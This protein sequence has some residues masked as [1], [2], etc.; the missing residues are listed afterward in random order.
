MLAL[1]HHVIVQACS[2]T[3]TLNYAV[4]GD[5][6][7]IDG[8]LSNSYINL[9]TSLGVKISLP[10]S[11]ISSNFIE[12][13]KRFI[14]IKENN[15]FTTLGPGLI[16]ASIR[17]RFLIPLLIS[18]SFKRKLIN[19]PESVNILKSFKLDFNFGLF[20][21]FG[22]NGLI[23]KDHKAHSN[24]GVLWLK[25]IYNS[26]VPLTALQ[27]SLYNALVS[28]LMKKHQSAVQKATSSLYMY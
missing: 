16:L 4:L 17:N 26:G 23:L 8:E 3:P 25:D 19:I 14:D 1:T 28:T 10:K 18:E 15:D 12:F 13:A 5:D 6:V 20:A 24:E 11:I 9:M 22:I 21:L 27:Y 2:P 7:G